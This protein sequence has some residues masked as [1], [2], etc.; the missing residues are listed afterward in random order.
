MPAYWPTMNAR[1]CTGSDIHDV[2]SS[3][4]SVTPETMSSRCTRSASVT[5]SSK[6]SSG[7]GGWLLVSWMLSTRRACLLFLFAMPCGA[8]V[9]GSW[10]DK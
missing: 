1:T 9:L 7:A 4:I 2:A 5:S 3:D 6:G 8:V 10:H